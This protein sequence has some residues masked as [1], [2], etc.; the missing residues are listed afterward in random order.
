MIKYPELLYVFVIRMETS[1]NVKVINLKQEDERLG[2]FSLCNQNP[3][4][5]HCVLF[6][7]HTERNKIRKLYRTSF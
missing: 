7:F 4:V 3:F 2:L 1:F 6:F 5:Q